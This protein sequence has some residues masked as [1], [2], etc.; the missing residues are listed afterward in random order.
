MPTSQGP[1]AFSVPEGMATAVQSRREAV[2]TS[3][4]TGKENPNPRTCTTVL[5]EPTQ[6]VNKVRIMKATLHK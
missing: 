3:Q 5:P 2:G 4:E 6:K 1:S